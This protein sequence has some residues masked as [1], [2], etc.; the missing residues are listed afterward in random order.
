MYRKDIIDLCWQLKLNA[1]QVQHLL[2]KFKEYLDANKVTK[3]L[4]QFNDIEAERDQA[5]DTE[6]IYLPLRIYLAD[7]DNDGQKEIITIKNKSLA[8]RFFSGIRIIRK[9]F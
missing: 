3:V 4:K 7:V 5:K 2:D 6:H 9:I 1:K 8:P